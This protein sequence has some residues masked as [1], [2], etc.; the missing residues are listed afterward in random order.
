LTM[1]KG[2]AAGANHSLA[3]RFSSFIQYP[4]DVSKDLLLLYNTNSANSI[5]VM[6]YYLAQRP[7]VSNA[8]V[9]PIGCT[10]TESF[11]PSEYTNI[12]VPQIGSWL[13]NNPTKRPQ[14]VILFLDIPSRVHTNRPPWNEDAFNL[15]AKA[16]VSYSVSTQFVGWQ[17]FVMHLNM[18]TANDCKAYI[19]KLE[20]SLLAPTPLA[21][22]ET[23]T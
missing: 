21:I 13:T 17:P 3:A 9:L 6:S 4:V 16:S 7:M 5:D 11:L 2:I 10:N 8:N 19:D 15:G 18:G 22:M 20:Y 12:F 14:Y 1:V 23:Q